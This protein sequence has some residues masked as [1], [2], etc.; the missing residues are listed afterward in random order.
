MHCSACILGFGFG[1][2]WTMDTGMKRNILSIAM[3]GTKCRDKEVIEMMKLEQPILEE[4]SVNLVKS[5]LF[6]IGE[7]MFLHVFHHFVCN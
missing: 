3:D 5:E 1:F 6:S 2:F 7:S 4:G